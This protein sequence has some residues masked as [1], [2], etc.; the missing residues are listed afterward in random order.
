MAL[1]DTI[2]VSDRDTIEFLVAEDGTVPALNLNRSA[3]QWKVA[4]PPVA[5]AIAMG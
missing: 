5:I 2:F 1:S 3:I 4:T